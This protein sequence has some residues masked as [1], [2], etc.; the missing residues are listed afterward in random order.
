MRRRWKLLHPIQRNGTRTVI[1]A[2]SKRA[3][4]WDP[5]LYPIRGVM[6]PDKTRMKIRVDKNDV[7]LGSPNGLLQ[8]P[9]VFTNSY[10]QVLLLRG[11]LVTE[12]DS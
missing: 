9:E 2:F 4:G 5:L 3:A 11:S 8:S 1:L 6:K 10:G 7:E 12:I